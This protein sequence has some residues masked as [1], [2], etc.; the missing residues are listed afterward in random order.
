MNLQ[1]KF[2]QNLNDPSLLL[3]TASEWGSDQNNHRSLIRQDVLAAL[4]ELGDT[5]THYSQIMSL[6]IPPTSDLA[7]ISISHTEGLGGFALSPKTEILGLDIERKDRVRT[8]VITRVSEDPTGAPSPTHQWSAMEASFKA[9]SRHFPIKVLSQI[10]VSNWE[11]RGPEIWSF[12]AHLIS[13]P[14]AI[15]LNGLL[16][17]DGDHLICISGNFT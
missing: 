9:I 7:S 17:E 16:I 1:D 15:K 13:D 14:N 5:I 6:E 11:E 3:K 12:V 8:E 2:R 10:D 4:K